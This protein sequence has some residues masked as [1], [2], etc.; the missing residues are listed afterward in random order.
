MLPEPVIAARVA[1][2]FAMKLLRSSALFLMMGCAVLGFIAQPEVC[3]L[4][5]NANCAPN[6]RARAIYARLVAPFEVVAP[7]T[8]DAEMIT[9]ATDN[10]PHLVLK[11]QVH[12]RKA[13]IP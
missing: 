13:A 2:E 7:Q 6:P 10:D 11:L 8:S 9:K 1:T 12:Q 3:T 4:L 5:E